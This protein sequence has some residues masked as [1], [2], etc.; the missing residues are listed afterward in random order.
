MCV[1]RASILHHFL[2][3]LLQ[4]TS[5]DRGNGQG[6]LHRQGLGRTLRVFMLLENSTRLE[7]LSC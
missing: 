2:V 7:H 3:L 5:S 1:Q 4:N 6:M